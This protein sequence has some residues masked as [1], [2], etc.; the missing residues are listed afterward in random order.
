M[1]SKENIQKEI[2]TYED[3]IVFNLTGVIQGLLWNVVI[4]HESKGLHV[5][6]INK[7]V[8]SVVETTFHNGPDNAEYPDYDHE[9]V[10]PRIERLKNVLALYGIKPSTN[11]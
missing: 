5:G 2:N 4:D 11:V 7:L 1:T 6:E 9:L 10:K 8:R 3:A